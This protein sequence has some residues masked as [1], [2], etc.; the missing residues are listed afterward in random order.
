MEKF[1][2]SKLST[3]EQCPFKYKLVYI[4][5][6][7]VD[8][9]NIATYFGSLVHYIEEKI[10]NYIKAGEEIDYEKL[11]YLFYNADFTSKGS[12]L[13]GINKIRELYPVEF[14][15]PDK[16]GKTYA[17]KA[18]IYI[19]SG[20]KRL[21]TFM[22]NNPNLE[23]YA[24]EQP[25]TLYYKDYTFQGFI[26]RIFKD[27]TTNSYL[28]EDIKTYSSPLDKS[29]LTTPLQFVIYAKAL[30]TVFEKAEIK[31]AYDL[32][33]CD[34]KQD[35]GTKG[36]IERGISKINKLLDEIESFNYAPKPCP[37]CHWC[38]FSGTYPNQPEEAKNL[39]PYFC[40]WT[41]ENKDFSVEYDWMGIENHESILEAF[42]ESKRKTKEKIEKDSIKIEKID[43]TRRFLLR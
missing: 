25:F 42:K 14:L 4:D 18:D 17:D 28:I 21:E 43:K 19:N 16:N 11:T 26:D 1:S 15:E 27:K 36:F 31:C 7:R 3:Y 29:A 40:H 6:I 35:A 41:R 34:L 38:I 24:T 39:C 30:E 22:K 9:G 23:I 2:Y 20:I 32:P 12:Q 37:L 10:G 13:L 8:Q 33:L 5:K